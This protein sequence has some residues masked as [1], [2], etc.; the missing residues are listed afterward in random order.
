MTAPASPLQTRL[1]EILVEHADA[2]D[3]PAERVDL[4][5][6]VFGPSGLITDSL[7]VLDALCAIEADFDVTIPDEDLT[8]ALFESVTALAAYVD[9]RIAAERSA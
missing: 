8:E 2:A 1:C 3:T 4:S 5:T 6:P 9:G 7:R